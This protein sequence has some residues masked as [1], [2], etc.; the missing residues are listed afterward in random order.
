MSEYT[1]TQREYVSLKS[2]LTKAINSKK[3]QNI[4]SECDRALAIFFEK[5]YPDD[6]SRW[7][8]AKE[9]ASLQLRRAVG[10]TPYYGDHSPSYPS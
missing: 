5:G 2:R 4:V 6:W 9:D 10:S 1:L 8:R 7:E 3:Y